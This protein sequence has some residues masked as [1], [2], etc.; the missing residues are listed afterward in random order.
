MAQLG[1]FLNT[2]MLRRINTSICPFDF[3][4]CWLHAVLASIG[5]KSFMLTLDHGKNDTY[6]TIVLY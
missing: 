1:H 3:A 2:R 5:D 6:R 4:L